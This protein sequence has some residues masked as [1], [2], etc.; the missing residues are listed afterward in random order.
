MK[1]QYETAGGEWTALSLSVP[2]VSKD[3]DVIET[4]DSEMIATRMSV[5]KIGMAELGSRDYWKYIKTTAPW[6]NARVEWCGCF[7]LW[8][9]HQAG[10]FESWQF[11]M[12]KGFLYR[13]PLTTNPLPGDAA[14]YHKNN[15]HA[16]V[17]DVNGESISTIDG[18]D[19]PSP[20]EVMH[21]CRQKNE[22]A[23]F[24]RIG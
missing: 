3:R 18:N 2:A 1:I 20:G 22:V 23:G 13:L 16:L 21:N 17:I 14:Y 24:Y 5:I 4:D 7:L 10:L 6:A 19:G 9:Y 15:H 8:C 11:E 12:S